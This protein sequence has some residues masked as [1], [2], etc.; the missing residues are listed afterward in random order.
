MI[1]LTLKVLNAAGEILAERGGEGQAEL[2][3]LEEYQPGDQIVIQSSQYPAHIHCQVDD[4]LR[5]SLCYLTK[6]L[7]YTVP[8]GERTTVYSKRAFT[9]VRHFIY[10]RVAQD[11]EVKNYRNLA[12]NVCDQHKIE[13]CYPHADANVETRGEA[14]FEAKNAIDGVYGNYSHGT[15]PFA[16]WGINRDPNACMTLNFGRT[17]EIDRLGICL[18]ADFPHD[19]YWTAGTVTFSDGSK[20]VLQFEKTDLPQYFSIEK[21]KIQWLTFDKLIKA[22]DESPF[23][24]LTQMEVWG[25]DL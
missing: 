20:E 14:V 9:G 11:F 1:T 12:L 18:R 23:P 8:F 10:A 17:V 4:V 24:A 25:T 7:V 2:C 6:D 13:G 19:S 21:R 22:D 15:W 3:Y 5:D 16:S